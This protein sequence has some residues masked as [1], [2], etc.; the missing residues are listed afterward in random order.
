MSYYFYESEHRPRFTHGGV[1]IWG[2]RFDV[3]G[4]PFR[5]YFI[6]STVPDVQPGMEIIPETEDACMAKADK[7]QCKG[8]TCHVIGGIQKRST[9]GQQKITKWA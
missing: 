8:K 4:P 7:L 2:G 1:G 3:A 6:C 9:N 5:G